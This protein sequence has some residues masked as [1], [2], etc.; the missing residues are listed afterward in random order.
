[1]RSAA[2]AHSTDQA[3]N[4]FFSHDGSDNS[5]LAD[6]AAGAGFLTFP[7]GENIAAGFNSVRSLVLAWMWCAPVRPA[8][9]LSQCAADVSHS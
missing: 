6:R 5:T 2:E 1:M 3:T 4:N 8:S 9:L 7:L